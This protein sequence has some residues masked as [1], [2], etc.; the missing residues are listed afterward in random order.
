MN[1]QR[2][3]SAARAGGVVQTCTLLAV[4]ECANVAGR[5][6]Y[7]V[8]I[9]VAG[10]DGDLCGMIRAHIAAVLVIELAPRT[11]TDAGLRATDFARKDF[12]AELQADL[13]GCGR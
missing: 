6:D 12:A 13:A 10:L 4:Y 11:G 7:L 3:A 9:P 2:Q 8:L 5:G 1:T